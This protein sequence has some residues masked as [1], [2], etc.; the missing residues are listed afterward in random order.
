MFMWVSRV[1]F[2]A[3]SSGRAVMA[4]LRLA[5]FEDRSLRACH[6]SIADRRLGKGEHTFVKDR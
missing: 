6:V 3:V 5:A 4:A 2:R 1:C